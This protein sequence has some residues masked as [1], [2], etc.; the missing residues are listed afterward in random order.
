MFA[1]DELY[2]DD[3]TSGAIFDY[4]VSLSCDD[5]DTYVPEGDGRY[6]P[7]FD[8]PDELRICAECFDKRERKA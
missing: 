5:C 4:D 7:E 6:W 3:V 2:D 8:A 1:G